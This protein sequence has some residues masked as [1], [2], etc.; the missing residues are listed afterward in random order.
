M[1][2]DPIATIA[3]RVA[4]LETAR[5]KA[6]R[7]APAFFILGVLAG[8]TGKALADKGGVSA[9]VRAGSFVLLDAAGRERGSLSIEEGT[10]VLT[11]KDENGRVTAEIGKAMRVWPITR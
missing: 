6:S 8:F 9:T 1:E 2:P 10:A 7:L 4:A 3:R 5:P 11:L